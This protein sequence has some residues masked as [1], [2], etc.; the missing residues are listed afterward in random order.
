MSGLIDTT[1]SSSACDCC[2]ASADAR[3]PVSSRLIDSTAGA[4]LWV[5][6]AAVDLTTSKP[7]LQVRKLISVGGSNWSG[8]SASTCA[9]RAS[10]A[11]RSAG[12]RWSRSRLRPSICG[13]AP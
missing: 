9:M 2:R 1:R 13:T 3:W 5:A 6:R 4:P 10:S 12:T 11:A 8:P 7:P